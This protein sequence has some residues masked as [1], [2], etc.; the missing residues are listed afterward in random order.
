MSITFSKNRTTLNSFNCGGI[1]I[2]NFEE[3]NSV[4]ITC[5]LLRKKL[6]TNIYNVKPHLERA[7]YSEIQTPS[8]KLKEYEIKKND[9]KTPTPP[10]IVDPQ[11]WPWV[12]VAQSSIRSGHASMCVP[13]SFRNGINTYSLIV[14]ARIEDGI[15]SFFY[16]C[17]SRA[18]GGVSE[19]E[20]LSH[21][22]VHPHQDMASEAGF[23]KITVLSFKLWLVD[24][25]NCITLSNYNNVQSLQIFPCLIPTTA[26][27]LNF[28][29]S[30][31]L[32]ST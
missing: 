28:C 31:I 21:T 14:P 26:F 16:Y 19:E 22:D 20:N 4:L 17:M 25:N 24:E 18:K 9:S 27:L 12:E 10:S 29:C 30:S 6:L 3:F 2:Q 13:L 7:T 1:S 11:A 8:E 15:R 23:R 32:N 5:L